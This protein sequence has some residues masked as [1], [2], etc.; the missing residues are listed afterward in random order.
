MSIRVNCAIA[1]CCAHKKNALQMMLVAGDVTTMLLSNKNSDGT[2]CVRM[3]VCV[4][5]FLRFLLSLF[6]CASVIT[7]E[8]TSKAR[9]STSD[10][11]QDRT[12]GSIH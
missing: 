11:Y 3:C 4:G 5:T 12:I 1:E 9:K 2:M 6:V 7:L 8:Q 10:L